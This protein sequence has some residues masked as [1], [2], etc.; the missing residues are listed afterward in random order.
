MFRVN[1][2][3]GIRNMTLQGLQ[4]SLGARTQYGTK[5]PNWWCICYIESEQ[6]QQM[7]VLG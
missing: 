6:V 7:L 2:G 3:T 4:G 5:R 1:N